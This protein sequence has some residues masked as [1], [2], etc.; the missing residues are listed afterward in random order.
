MAIT[1]PAFETN[2]GVV[3][4]LLGNVQQALEAARYNAVNTFHVSNIAS[5]I[6]TLSQTQQFAIDDVSLG[7]TRNF[8]VV[9]TISELTTGATPAFTET[10]A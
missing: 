6:T 7:V 2:N 8:E 5:P 10:V 1:A 3:A 9:V 4:G